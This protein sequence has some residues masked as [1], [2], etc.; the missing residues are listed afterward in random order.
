MHWV[1]IIVC[2]ATFINVSVISWREV[3]LWRKPDAEFSGERLQTQ[4]ADKRYRTNM[5]SYNNY[6][7]TRLS[8]I[9]ELLVLYQLLVQVEF[10]VNLVYDIP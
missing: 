4:V 8:R 10:V 3:F 1:R 7:Y 6:V 2:N 5:L 9:L